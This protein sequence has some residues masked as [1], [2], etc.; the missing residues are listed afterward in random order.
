MSVTIRARLPKS[1]QNGLA[2]LEGKFAANPD[3]L[4]IV[5]GIVRADTI[6]D[7]PH[8]DDDPRVV[9]TVLLHIEA[10]ESESDRT[11]IDKLLRAVYARRTGKRAL[12]FEDEPDDEVES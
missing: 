1:D 6:E 9:K 11:R 2:H 7:R 4:W 10:I 5:I 3:D 8:D 12:P